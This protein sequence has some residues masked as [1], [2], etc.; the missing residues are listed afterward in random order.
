[1]EATRR[2]YE[3]TIEKFGA[4]RCMFESNFPVDKA[5]C[6]YTVLWNSF[7]HLTAKYSAAEKAAL[8]HDTA[9]RVYR[10]PA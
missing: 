8:F 4:A 9:V 2:W 1:M 6:S 3:V 5:S 7:Q 10:L